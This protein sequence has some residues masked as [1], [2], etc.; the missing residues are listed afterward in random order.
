MIKKIPGGAFLE[1]ALTQL[2]NNTM[3]N[4]FGTTCKN[5]FKL[6]VPIIYNGKNYLIVNKAVGIFCQPP[7]LREWHKAQREDP[8]VLL[9]ILRENSG[10]CN[11]Q[12]LRTVHRLDSRVTGGVLIAKNKNSAVQFAKNLK[13]GGNFGFAFTRKYVALVSGT[14]KE[15]VSEQGII[16]KDGMITQY[17]RIKENCLVVQL[18]TG[19]KHQIRK[20]LAQVL[21]QPLLN[22]LKYGGKQISGAGDQIALHSAFIKTKIGL[23]VN[24]HLIPVPSSETALWSECLGSDGHFDTLIQNTL[25]ENWK[26]EIKQCEQ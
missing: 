25:L 17:K 11:V 20:H 6:R 2:A 26:E 21:G 5:I 9:D 4:K 3:P 22:D 8:P 16:C 24:E 14:P 18:H 19:K 12:E 13:K 10:I 7:D 23:Q 15:P 1:I